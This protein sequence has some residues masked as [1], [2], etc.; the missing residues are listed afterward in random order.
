MLIFEINYNVVLYFC[1]SL[2]AQT[3]MFNMVVLLIQWVSLLGVGPL[4]FSISCFPY[5]SNNFF[6]LVV[7]AQ[8]CVSI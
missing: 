2:C 8:R 5:K 4:Y 1:P 6:L 3:F 7:H